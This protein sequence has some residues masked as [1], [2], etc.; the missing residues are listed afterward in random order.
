MAMRKK[1]IRV[2]DWTLEDANKHGVVLWS[3][4][5]WVESQKDRIVAELEKLHGEGVG[6]DYDAYHRK[7]DLILCALLIG[8]G[9]EEVVESWDKIAKYYS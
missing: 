3:E 4:R 2:S 5:A 8:L 9:Y 6:H 1:K 7:G